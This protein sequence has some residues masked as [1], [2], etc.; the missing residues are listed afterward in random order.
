[1]GWQDRVKEGA[2]TSPSGLRFVFDFEDVS[3]LPPKKT[4]GFD[5]PDAVGT[6]VQDN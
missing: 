1:M 5:F 2:Y 4:K 3:V 6:Y